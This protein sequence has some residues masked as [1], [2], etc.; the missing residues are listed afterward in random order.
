MEQRANIK[1]CVKLGKTLTEILAIL[2]EAFR[3]KVLEPLTKRQ[4]SMWKSSEEIQIPKK[5]ACKNQT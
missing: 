1:F 2:Q 3:N 4:N 5:C